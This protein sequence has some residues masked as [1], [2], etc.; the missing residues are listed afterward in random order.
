MDG[1]DTA[2]IADLTDAVD[3]FDGMDGDSADTETVS[4]PSTSPYRLRLVSVGG[5]RPVPDNQLDLATSI[6]VGR[7]TVQAD[8]GRTLVLTLGPKT[9]R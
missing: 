5:Q 1:A 9:S 3:L 8:D 6:A 2:T 4:P 7:R